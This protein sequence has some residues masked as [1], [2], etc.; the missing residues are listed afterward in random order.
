MNKSLAYL[1]LIGII[2]CI[3]VNCSSVKIPA[4]TAA[5]DSMPVKQII[6]TAPVVSPEKSLAL[7]TV[8]EGFEI[9]LVASEPLVSTPVALNF[10]DKNRM[11][12]VE[13]Q[14]YMP[15]AAGTGEEI[16]TGK[17]VILEDKNKD[18]IVDNRKVFLDSLDFFNCRY[19]LRCCTR[20][21]IAYI[22]YFAIFLSSKI[23][24]QR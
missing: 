24:C 6:E 1:T 5:S 17:I 8:E 21:Y 19:T 4:L 18:G 16:P 12:V 20:V 22:C 2:A 15:N 11:W 10:D 23:L 14:G 9:Q 3:L 7:M 13:M